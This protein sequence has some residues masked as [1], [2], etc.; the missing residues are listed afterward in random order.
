MYTSPQNPLAESSRSI[1]F[2][3]RIKHQTSKFVLLPACVFKSASFIRDTDVTKGERPI[4]DNLK[5]PQ[6]KHFK[7]LFSW[8]KKIIK[9]S[10]SSGRWSG[11]KCWFLIWT[12][13]IPSWTWESILK[14]DLC[15]CFPVAK[16]FPI[17]RLQHA[18]LPCPSLSPGVYSNSCPL[19][20]WCHPTI[21]SSV[22]PF[23]SCPQSFPA[24]GSFPV[25]WLFA[26]DWASTYIC[27]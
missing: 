11:L 18:R 26:S 12:Y 2:T 25:S 21:S 3:W 15:Y 8:A 4:L 16:S 7:V 19:S 13:L 9:S 17:H 5:Y 22:A 23:F 27:I 24:A 6:G 1:I 10:I 14:M 20:Q